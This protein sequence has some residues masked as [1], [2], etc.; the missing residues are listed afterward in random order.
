MGLGVPV[1]SNMGLGVPVSSNMGLGVPVSSSGL[2]AWVNI[3]DV[4]KLMSV[5]ECNTKC[6]W[7]N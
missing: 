7:V 5:G 6:M 4:L 2:I 1:S 3:K